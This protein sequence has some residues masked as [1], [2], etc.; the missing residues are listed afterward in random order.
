[1]M[2]SRRHVVLLVNPPLHSFS[3][4]ANASR[5]TQIVLKRT[6]YKDVLLTITTSTSLD[7]YVS[8]YLSAWARAMFVPLN[9]EHCMHELEDYRWD[10]SDEV[11]VIDTSYPNNYLYYFVHALAHP[12]SPQDARARARLLNRS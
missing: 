7:I 8:P 10:T 4:Q 2:N 5:N 12:R 6:S 11:I 9:K 3:H 1:M